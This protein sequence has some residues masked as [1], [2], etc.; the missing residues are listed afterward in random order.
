VRD[1]QTHSVTIN[2]EDGTFGPAQPARRIYVT[3]ASTSATLVIKT[4][5][6]TAS[7]L[8]ISTGEQ[9]DVVSRKILPVSKY[10]SIKVYW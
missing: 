3:S 10:H 1:F 4:E 9:L 7:T 2:L 8:Q 5:F 6:A